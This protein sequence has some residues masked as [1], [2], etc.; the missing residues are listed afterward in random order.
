MSGA[1]PPRHLAI[2][3]DRLADYMLATLAGEID[4]STHERLEEQ[5]GG[6]LA[7]TQ[8][9]LIINLADVGFCDSSGLNTF[10]HLLR[11]ARARGVSIVFIGVRGRV[12]TVL[13]MTRLR[14]ALYVQPDLEA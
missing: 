8:A 11:Q 5:L 13:E 1:T 14:E 2:R 9:A 7:A 4:F 3:I 10:A 6:A 12:A